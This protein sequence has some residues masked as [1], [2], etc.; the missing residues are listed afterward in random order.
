[1]K[2]IESVRDVLAEIQGTLI[3]P[4]NLRNTFG[5]YNYRSCEGILESVKPM[6]K[7]LNATLLLTD[8]VKEVGGIVFC[9]ATASLSYKTGTVEVKAQAGIPPS[10]KGMDLSQIFGASSSYARKYAL[11]G[12]FLIDD[13][14]D[15]DTQ[16]NRT[17]TVAP[18]KGKFTPVQIK[19]IKDYA[20]SGGDLNNVSAKY[21]LSV[22][23]LKLLI[24]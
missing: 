16:D 5:K 15:A 2:K 14:K 17:E 13:N 21:G 20:K 11:N 22:E 24:S 8:E 4:K 23:D 3:A 18:K 10:K 12:L 19:K 6:L 1:M 7:S 9:E